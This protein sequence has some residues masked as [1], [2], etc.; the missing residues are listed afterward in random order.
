MKEIDLRTALERRRQQLE[1][2]FRELQKK[3][4][5]GYNTVRRVFK[6]PFEVRFRSILTVCEA[7]GCGLGFSIE[8]QI[9]DD[10]ESGTQPPPEE[11]IED[12]KNREST[13]SGD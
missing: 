8:N 12:L 6:T 7:M 11:V 2:T 4:K 3:T 13:E 10:I 5:L 1:L 9:P